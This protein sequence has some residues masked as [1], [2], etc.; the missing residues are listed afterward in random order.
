MILD[1]A[2]ACPHG[3]SL[4]K[5]QPAFLMIQYIFILELLIY[6]QIISW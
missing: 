6:L 1:I 4:I 2:Y 3:A 5:L